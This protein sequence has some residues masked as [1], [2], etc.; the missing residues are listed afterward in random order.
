[1]TGSYGLRDA[2]GRIRT[3]NYI[4]DAA[5]FRATISSNEPGVESK[6][7][8]DVSIN[9]APLEQPALIQ[10]APSQV[11]VA[12]APLL[13]ASS[14]ISYSSSVNHASPARL[15]SVGPAPLAAAL[16]QWAVNA[17]ISAP[18]VRVQQPW[19]YTAQW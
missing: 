7:P 10:A 8:A 2:D 9:G 12:H 4:A 17:P 5:G 3:V 19:G 16:N 14:G 6:S 13:A 1:M 11:V 15:V 18:V